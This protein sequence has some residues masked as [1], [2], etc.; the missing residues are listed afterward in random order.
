VI[1]D[2]D[3]A[4]NVEKTVEEVMKFYDLTISDKDLARA[5]YG[6]SMAVIALA[7]NVTLRTAQLLLEHALAIRELRSKN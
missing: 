7:L 4:L 3:E 2:P 5:S 6:L 1:L